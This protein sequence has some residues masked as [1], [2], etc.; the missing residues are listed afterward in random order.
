MAISIDGT[1]TI[2]G[3]AA[4]GLPDDS[5][6]A[7]ELSTKTF[8]SY[9]AICDRKAY[10]VDGGAFTSGAWRIR[11]L[12]FELYDPD[13]IVTVASNQFTLTA[14]TYLI[15]FSA[16][17]FDVNKHLAVLQDVTNSATVGIGT[18]EE[19]NVTGNGYTRSSGS[20]RIVI[21]GTTVYEIQHQSNASKT[22]NGFGKSHDV[23]S[24]IADG[25]GSIYT[26]VE[27]Y[28]EA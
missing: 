5:I 6:T 26:R 16:P 13:N 18:S 11:D 20:A 1:G 28:K 19:A 17:A 27:I 23:S 8:V 21:T 3:I 14:G 24:G 4:G 7:A 2:A 25:Y 12:N 10:N 9:A 22:L 15:V